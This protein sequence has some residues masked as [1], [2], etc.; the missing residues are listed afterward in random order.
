MTT[1]VSPTTLQRGT[2]PKIV[3]LPAV[4]LP[5]GAPEEI[6]IALVQCL[7]ELEIMHLQ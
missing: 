6:C 3:V 2:V 5:V 4:Q 7:A 1:N